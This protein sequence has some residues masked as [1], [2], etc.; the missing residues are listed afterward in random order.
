MEF[1]KIEFVFVSLRSLIFLNTSTDEEKQQELC[2]RLLT[3]SYIF[4]YGRFNQYGDLIKVFV[5]LRSLIFLNTGEWDYNYSESRYVFV[6]LRSLIFLNRTSCK[7]SNY[8]TYCFRLLTES[9][10]FK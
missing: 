3:E 9:Y 8:P 1:K 2:F 7:L 10:I 5:S 4:K 6:S